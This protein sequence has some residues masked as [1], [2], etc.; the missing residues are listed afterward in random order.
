[1]S[2]YN[3]NYLSRQ[4]NIPPKLHQT[5]NAGTMRVPSRL[6]TARASSEYDANHTASEVLGTDD[7]FALTVNPNGWANGGGIS[8]TTAVDEWIEVE[9]TATQ[10]ENEIVAQDGSSIAAGHNYH[11]PSSSEYGNND[12]GLNQMEPWVASSYNTF[13]NYAIGGQTLQSINSDLVA[14]TFASSPQYLIVQGGVNNILTSGDSDAT[15]QT[16]WD[17]LFTLCASNNVVPFP[18]LGFP[19]LKAGN[20]D[21]ATNLEKMEVMYNYIQTICLNNDFA[22]MDFTAVLTQPNSLRYG[23]GTYFESDNLH[24]NEVGYR[25]SASTIH[26]IYHPEDYVITGIE[27]STKMEN[28]ASGDFNRPRVIYI[29]TDDRSFR[30]V[31]QLSAFER[32]HYIR[33]KKPHST[34][35]LRIYISTC[36][37]TTGAA[38][39]TG[40]SR[41]TL[42]AAPKQVSYERGD[43]FF[44]GSLMSRGFEFKDDFIGNALRPEWNLTVIG[45]ATGAMQN[46]L[47]GKYRLTVTTSATSDEANLNFGSQMP[48]NV[49]QNPVIEFVHTMG[50]AIGSSDC[51]IGVRADANNYFGVEALSADVNWQ[52][53][54]VNGGTKTTVN[55]GE[56]K[57]ANETLYWRI[58]VD[59]DQKTATSSRIRFFKST[60]GYDN[61]VLVATITTNVSSSN[62]QPYISIVSKAVATTRTMDIDMY[63]ISQ[64]R[65]ASL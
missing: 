27:I 32:L 2:E 34:K 23:E 26:S 18:G 14:S 20:Y 46:A 10:V 21:S 36:D 63:N 40:I 58:V 11:D 30:Q 57:N 16:E 43:R 28:P 64:R 62:M 15:I 47:N 12:R 42:I 4:R 65:F 52:C 39:F 61:F 25:R 6:L 7:T 41:I 59:S 44:E 29:E 3:P 51:F 33:L 1:L 37:G 45:A 48:I 24:T 17:N 60:T 55:S 50:A 19:L 8:S 5:I 35:R 56:T 31:K 53:V 54:S 13:Q 49:S 9:W 22:Y 38:K